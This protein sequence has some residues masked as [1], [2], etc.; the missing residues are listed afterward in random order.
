MFTTPAI[1]CFPTGTNQVTTFKPTGNDIA[2]AGGAPDLLNW[3]VNRWSATAIVENEHEG[4]TGTEWYATRLEI[5][6][7]IVDRIDLLK[8]HSKGK[9]SPKRGERP[10]DLKG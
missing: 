9:T 1:R 5:P 6:F 4:E 10:A 3:F 7:E 2:S 8:D